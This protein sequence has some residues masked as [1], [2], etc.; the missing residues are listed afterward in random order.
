MSDI[1]D[2]IRIFECAFCGHRE[3]STSRI[4][5]NSGWDVIPYS[6]HNLCTNC[7]LRGWIEDIVRERNKTRE[8]G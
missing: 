1:E 6:D 2:V 7:E 3:T 8:E 4:L 5:A